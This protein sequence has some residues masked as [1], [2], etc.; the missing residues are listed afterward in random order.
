MVGRRIA[1][2]A[3]ALAILTPA[4]GAAAQDGSS[5]GRSDMQL[6]RRV[7]QQVLEYPHYTVFDSISVRLADGVVTVSGKVTRDNKREDIERRIA[8]VPGVAKVNNRIDVLPAS[9]SDDD[10]RSAIARAIYDHPSFRPYAARVNPPIHIIVERGR[11]TLEGVVTDQSERLQA[12]SLAG[13]YP[14]H[15]ITNNLMTEAEARAE[16]AR[17][18]R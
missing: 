13:G 16:L 8:K 10:L 5:V 3:L 12:Q 4:L 15:K 11:V 2:A 9:K 7:Q 17:T 14:S 6:L 1:T 18:S